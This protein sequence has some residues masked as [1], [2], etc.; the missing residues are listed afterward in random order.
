MLFSNRKKDFYNHLIHKIE[1]DIWNMELRIITINDIREGI[2]REFD[3]VSEAVKGMGEEIERLKAEPKV[4]MDE[5]KR[6]A[7]VKTKNEADAEEMQ[8]QMIGKWSEKEQAYI[9]GIDGEVKEVEKK[10]DGGKEFAGL[11]ARELKKL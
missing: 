4:D 11:I 10:I 8:N 9:G 5:V 2:R 3:R 7:E 1:R 6:I